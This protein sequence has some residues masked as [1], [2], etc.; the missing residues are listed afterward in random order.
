M[1]SLCYHL[2]KNKCAAPV[3]YKDDHR[4]DCGAFFQV[5]HGGLCKSSLRCCWWFKETTKSRYRIQF[6]KNQ[7]FQWLWKKIMKL[8]H[9]SKICFWKARLA[10]LKPLWT[11]NTSDRTTWRAVVKETSPKSPSATHARTPARA[12]SIH[13]RREK[14]HLVHNMKITFV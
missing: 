10:S 12:A 3:S 7:N 4:G 13:H 2:F 6:L 5:E 14:P 8:H 11:K 1:V 9:S